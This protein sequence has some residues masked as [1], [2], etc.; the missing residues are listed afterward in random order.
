MTTFSPD[1][2]NLDSKRETLREIVGS[3]FVLLGVVYLLA[4]EVGRSACRSNNSSWMSS[5]S[6][7]VLE[8][9]PKQKPRLG[10]VSLWG[11]AR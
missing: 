2:K 10:A 11:S 3:R 5:G 1:L 9:A 6:W 4:A 7:L 8:R